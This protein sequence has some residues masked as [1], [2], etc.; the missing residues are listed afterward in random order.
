VGIRET[1][2]NGKNIYPGNFLYEEVSLKGSHCISS[3]EEHNFNVP[4]M[5][6]EKERKHFNR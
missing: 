3:A 2:H 6:V 1:L 4:D 5:F